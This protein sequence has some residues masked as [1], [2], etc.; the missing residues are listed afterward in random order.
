MTGV[1]VFKEDA[2]DVFGDGHF[3]GL[4]L[5]ELAGGARGSDAFGDGVG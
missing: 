1:F 5:G 2:A 4:A 3:D